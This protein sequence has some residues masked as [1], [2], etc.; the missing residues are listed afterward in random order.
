MICANYKDLII[1]ENLKSPVW[2][3]A[4]AWLKADSWKDVPVGRTEIDGT[5]IYVLRSSRMGKQAS[6]CQ[7]ESHRLYAD[8]QMPIKGTELQLV[9]LRDGLK[10]TVPYSEEKDVD[11]LEGD[12]AVVH[13]IILSFPLAA[14]Y[15]P[16][17]VH[18]PNL[19]VDNKSG[20][21]EKIV[22]KVAL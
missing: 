10:V 21:V 5:N 17:D 4:L 14:V 22:L 7:Y 8:I 1:P 12:P 11:F 3:K 19:S 6:E 20:E 13:S 16:G 18:K 9:C 15:F 2:E